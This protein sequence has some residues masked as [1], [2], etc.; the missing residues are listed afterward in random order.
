VAG[1]VRNLTDKAAYTGGAVQGFAPPLVY[2][3][4][5]APRTYGLRLRYDLR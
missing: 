5:A 2:A 3:T 4:I 1:Y